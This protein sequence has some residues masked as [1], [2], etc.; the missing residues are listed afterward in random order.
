[1]QPQ[2]NHISNGTTSRN[3]EELMTDGGLLGKQMKDHVFT[4]QIKYLRV[5]CLISFTWVKA[6]KFKRLVTLSAYGKL[7]SQ[8]L[9]P[10]L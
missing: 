3:G 4:S 1:M 8:P 10:Q 6:V 9:I 5:D 2:A 7:G